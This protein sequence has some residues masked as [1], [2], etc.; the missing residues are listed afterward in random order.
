M[1]K[2]FD[3][4]AERSLARTTFSTCPEV[5]TSRPFST[6]SKYCSVEICPGSNE[7]EVKLLSKLISFRASVSS[8][9]M[10]VIQRVSPCLPT[11]TF[12]ITRTL[13]VLLWSEKAIEPNEI[14]PDPE[15]FAS[16][17]ISA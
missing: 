8:M 2:A 6:L 14:S 16:S 12:G 5:I 17:V 13:F 3:T 4:D 9:L 15:R 7:T 1:L 10:V 11:T